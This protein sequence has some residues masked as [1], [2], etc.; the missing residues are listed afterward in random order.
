MAEGWTMRKVFHLLL[1][2][3]M[4]FNVLGYAQMIGL[5]I[6]YSDTQSEK[7]GYAFIEIFG[8]CLFEFGAFSVATVLWFL[9]IKSSRAGQGIGGASSNDQQ[10]YQQGLL[11]TK[12]YCLPATI[13]IAFIGLSIHSVVVCGNILSSKYDSL[14]D[15]KYESNTHKKHLLSEGIFWILH[16]LTVFFCCKLMYARLLGLASYQQL[17]VSQKTPILTRMLV[18]MLTCASCYIMRGVMLLLARASLDTS[19]DDYENGILWWT[20]AMLIPSVF[21]SIL[22]FYPFRRLERGPF[23]IEGINSETAELLPAPVPPALIWKRFKRIKNDENDED[24]GSNTSSYDYTAYN[25]DLEDNDIL[26]VVNSDDS[27]I[28]EAMITLKGV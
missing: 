3:A 2:I 11:C 25:S 23:W 27:Y 18:T 16:G 4:F 28:D 24:L 21:P 7:L 19:E 17:P 13:C 20:L 12:F 10:F 22:L 6:S 26:H 5:N 9:T 8:R 1:F 15:W 14:E